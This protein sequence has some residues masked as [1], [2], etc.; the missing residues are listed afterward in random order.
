MSFQLIIFDLDG[1]LVDSKID[2][3]NSVRHTLKELGLRDVSPE[4]IYTFVGRGVEPLIRNSLAEAGGGDVEA[5]LRLFRAHYREHMVEHSAPFPG[6]EEVLRRLSP[7][8]KVVLTNK[9]KDLSLEMLEKLSLAPFFLDIFGGDSFLTKKP[10]PEG[11]RQIIQKFGAKPES[12]LIV[13]D[14]GVDIE[15][16]KRAGITTCGVTYGYRSVEELRLQC[17]DYM[18]DNFLEII[19]IARS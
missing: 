18:V 9:L 4:T 14:S 13:G 15:A 1:T 10:D 8:D 5:A 17:P 19:D 11:I 12:T 16:G 7:I 3:A 2:I 6:V